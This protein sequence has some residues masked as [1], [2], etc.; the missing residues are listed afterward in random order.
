[1]KYI[2]EIQ[3]VE[4][5]ANPL[6]WDVT[7]TT[8]N[9]TAHPSRSR[10]AALGKSLR[11]DGAT[12]RPASFSPQ[13]PIIRARSPPS[14]TRA[15]FEGGAPRAAAWHGDL[16]RGRGGSQA[17]PGHPSRCPSP[18]EEDPTAAATTRPSR[19]YSHAPPKAPAGGG[20][21]RGEA[22][23]A[24]QFEPAALAPDTLRET[25]SCGGIR[26]ASPPSSAQQRSARRRLR[27][28]GRGGTA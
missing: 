16:W 27:T 15:L 20:L 26:Q 12:H 2:C 24:G 19:P 28:W 21:L 1:M 7:P 6:R 4:G 17:R 11:R 18:Q 10:P 25:V 14:S 8:N 5:T 3:S 22:P 9:F 13:R 23:R